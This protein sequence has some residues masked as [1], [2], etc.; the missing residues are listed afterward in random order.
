MTRALR[1]N[2]DGV[3]Q[4]NLIGWI[5]DPERYP[6]EVA[7]MIDGQ[8]VGIVV[9]NEYRADL[10]A[11]GIDNGRFGFSIPIPKPFL[12]GASH[13]I[14][15]WI[16]KG[17]RLLMPPFYWQADASA[18]RSAPVQK[19]KA[20]PVSK[21][22]ETRPVEKKRALPPSHDQGKRALIPHMEVGSAI[23]PSSNRSKEDL[24]I[25]T[26]AMAE[27]DN[28]CRDNPSTPYY[29]R[30]R[31]AAIGSERLD[32]FV[33]IL[34]TLRGID[35]VREGQLPKT[36]QLIS[37]VMPAHNRQYL[38]DDAIRS[39]LAQSYGKWELIICDDASEDETLAVIDTLRDPR[40]K[41]VRNTKRSGAAVARNACL[42]QA[43]GDLIAYLDSDNVWHP[44]Y[45]EMMAE[46]LA[47][48]PGHQAAYAGYFDIEIGESRVRIKKCGTTPFH[49][50]DQIA[51]PYVDLN[52]FVH[53][54]TL[55]NVLGGFDERLSRRQDYD[56]I[57]RYCWVREPRSLP[58]ILNL[59]Q[60]IEKAEQITRVQKNDLTSPRIIADKIEGYYKNGV[61]AVLPPWI[62]K[63]TV[64]SWDMSRN[65]FAKAY[66]VAEALSK[67]VE[68]ELI[69]Y[70]FFE[71]E[72]FNPLAG[73]KPPFECKYFN[74]G[75][76][77]DFF[78]DVA[79]GVEA[80]TGDVIYAIKPRLT[81]FGI[82]LLAN[83]QTGKPLMLECNDL[84]T[85]VTQAR[86]T[87]NHA[88][89]KLDDVLTIG[90]NAKIPYELI[91][92]EI[93]DPLVAGIPS[94]FTHN[95][96]LNLHYDRRCLYMRN[97]KDDA[98]YRPESY[99]RDAVRRE[100]GFS[101]NDRVILFGGLVRKHKGVFE[102]VDL[103]NALD[104]PRY[105][106]LVVGSR[107]TPDLAML[108]KGQRDN[109][110]ILPPQP[111]ER[112]AAINL[113]S[114]LV[115]LWQD[116]S[117]PAGHY[118]SPYKMSDA[119]AMGPTIIA[120]P[121][122]DLA[123]F[124]QRDLVLKVPFGDQPRLVN[125]IKQVFD[126]PDQTAARR[127]RARKFFE[128]EFSYPAVFPAFA[129]GVAGL[130]PDK[131]Y[132]ASERFARVFSKYRNKTLAER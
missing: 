96:N 105:K 128:R 8:R 41:I 36:R 52:S 19:S 47:H 59:Y 77:P 74:G 90:D 5:C 95:I 32:H 112:M 75:T 22:G 100:M 132:P 26:A 60:R 118:Q 129:L 110:I 98:L 61:P 86:S 6:V 93:L 94:V 85:V 66:C 68:V 57:A 15:L 104:D 49:M 14:E 20:P 46:E 23:F 3:R 102:L 34:N 82:G 17:E 76:F 83:Y 39:V 79:K 16:N 43:K 9:A 81:S 7:A 72:I 84:E 92:S 31:L 30:L 44:R 117:V 91:W 115:I 116:P 21:S 62:K 121:T 125:T 103:L 27:L 127:V 37:I 33:Q 53:R 78:P 25:F 108:S 54:R 126:N 29:E 109:I 122:S 13:R 69:S 106:L 120:S 56:L 28:Y 130:K 73:K 88:Q 18:K 99:N 87:D 45:L 101:P 114:D 124:A 2:F 35:K 64:L 48:W 113:A 119:L 107:E 42:K 51:V 65:H 111:P 11:A 55:Y 40:I 38:I 1:G 10:E 131:V 58:N 89:R 63:V 80:I 24:A 4:D 67:H 50:E 123:D 70:R 97:I 71:D 12:T